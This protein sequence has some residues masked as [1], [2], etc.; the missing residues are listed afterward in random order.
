M[1]A[2]GPAEKMNG[3][4]DNGPVQSILFNSRQ[5]CVVT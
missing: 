5:D 2:H 3:F 1:W 4:L